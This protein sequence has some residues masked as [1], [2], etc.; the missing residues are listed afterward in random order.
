M[1]TYT[2]ER[3]RRMMAL[4]ARPEGVSA[5]EADPNDVGEMTKAF[6]RMVRQG[7]GRVEQLAFRRLHFWLSPEDHAAWVASKTPTPKPPAKPRPPKPKPHQAFT[8]KPAP[9][10]ITATPMRS[11][12]WWDKDARPH[13]DTYVEPRITSETKVTICIARQPE[14]WLHGA[15]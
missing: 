8:I 5:Y 9:A 6:K 11:V 4:A 13:H 7:F 2:T 1:S 14:D 10:R 3:T 15:A 12:A